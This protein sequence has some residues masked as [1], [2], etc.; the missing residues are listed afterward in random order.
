[1]LWDGAAGLGGVRLCGEDAS[2]FEVGVVGEAVGFAAQDLEEIV[3]SLDAA[4]AGPSG[5]VPAEH[6]LVPGEERV[7]DVA[8]LEHPLVARITRIQPHAKRQLGW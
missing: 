7:D 6:Y 8:E 5:V 4:V 3:G 1:M 2:G